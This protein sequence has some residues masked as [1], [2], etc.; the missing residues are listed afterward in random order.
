M[1]IL[2]ELAAGLREGDRLHRLITFKP[3]PAPYS[4]SFMH[5]EEWLDFN[6]MQTWNGVKLIYPMVAKDYN[7]KPVKPVLMAEGAYEAGSE[8]GFEVTPLWVCRQAYYSYLAGGHHT[9]GHNDSWRILP[10]WKKALDAPGAQQMDILRKIFEARAE[11]WLLVPD[12]SLFASGGQTDGKVLHLAARHQD[13]KWAMVYLADKADFSVNMSELSGAD[14]NAFWVDPKT[15]NSVPVGSFSNEGVRSFSTPEGWEDSLL[16]LE[17]GAAVT[18]EPAFPVK[19]SVDGRYLEDAKGV[20]FF[21]HADTAWQAPKRLSVEDFGYYLGHR[22]E[23]GFNTVMLH[24][25]SKELTPA[26][27]L[28]GHPPFEPLDDITKPLEAYWQHLDALLDLAETRGF[29]V[30]IAPLWIRW[31]GNDQHGWRHQL[32]DTNAPLYGRWLGQ[33]YAPRKN[34]VWILGGD[35]NPNEK[36]AAINALGRAIKSAAP[37]HLITVHNAPEHSSARFFGDS[38]WLDINL[39]YT[40][41]EAP[42]QVL[43]EWNRPGKARPIILGE[44]GYEEESNDQRGGVPWRVRR[45]AYGAVLSGALGGHAFG[46]KH[47]WRMDDQWKQALDSPASRQMA[48]VKQLFATRRWWKLR[49]DDR[50]QLIPAGRGNPGENGYVSAALTDDRDLAIIYLPEVRSITV[51]LARMTAGDGSGIRARWMD[52]VSGIFAPVEGSPL[53][54]DGPREFTPPGKNAGGDNDWVLLLEGK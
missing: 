48:H 32:N 20:P 33:R 26:N 6:S 43:G 14:I 49:P 37:H 50:G 3:D 22:E 18:A 47:L 25:F 7:L 41:R 1:P 35:A 30:M 8:Y 5:G 2:R 54:N 27:N 10:T 9:Y 51:N 36:T 28:N 40:Y 42:L 17:Q 24:T 52:P 13:G 44:S 39:A 45:Q 15:G 29:L 53:K 38:D 4:S 34:I 31:G 19:L 23:L 16:I 12:Q 21:V 46:Q 11:W